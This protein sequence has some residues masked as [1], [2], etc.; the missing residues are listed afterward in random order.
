MIKK[1][2]KKDKRA[3]FKDL[4]LSF[5]SL[6]RS[7]IKARAGEH[8]KCRYYK[9]GTD[10]CAIGR[11]IKDKALCRRLD[12]AAARGSNASVDIDWVFD[13][14]SPELQAYEKAFLRLMQ[15]F[16]DFAPYWNETGLSEKGQLRASQIRKQITAGKI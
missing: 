16:H 12:R 4:T 13:E 6:T 10:G 1:K 8:E 2:T 9:A 7:V 5:T 3:F 15:R 14:L 11:H